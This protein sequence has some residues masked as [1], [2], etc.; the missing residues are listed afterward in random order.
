MYL[1]FDVETNGLPKSWGAPVT[2]VDNWPR[3]VQIAWALYDCME[4]MVHS[5]SYIIKLPEPMPEKLVEIHGINDDKIAAFGQPAVEVFK[6]FNNICSHKDVH[7]LIA[8]NIKFD[9]NVVSSEAIRWRTGNTHTKLKQFCTMMK[10]TAHCQLPKKRGGGYK[11]PKL[12]ELYATLFN[13]AEIED[14]HNA[15]V[16][17]FATAKCFFYMLE[18]EIIDPW[19]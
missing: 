18:N 8:H 12:A 17:V 5:A 3:V 2:D 9:F 7:L 15:M 1:F 19:E 16:D 4:Y 14:A 11:W 13:G 10:S 6:K